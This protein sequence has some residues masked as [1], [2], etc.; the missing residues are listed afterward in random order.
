[1]IGSKISDAMEYSGATLTKRVKGLMPLTF[2][3]FF[4]GASLMQAIF[5]LTEMPNTIMAYAS[6]FACGCLIAMA[7]DTIKKMVN[8]RSHNVVVLGI[9]GF[10]MAVTVVDASNNEGK[11]HSLIGLHVGDKDGRTDFFFD[12]DTAEMLA[13]NFLHLVD[14]HKIDRINSGIDPGV[15]LPTLI[16]LVRKRHGEDAV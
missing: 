13:R 4:V 6:S 7:H 11:S 16:E 14:T 5:Y 10:E 15:E 12:A 9:G 2:T 3:A 8:K 1:M